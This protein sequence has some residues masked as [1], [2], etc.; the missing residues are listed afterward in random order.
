MGRRTASVGLVR[1][2]A[3]SQLDP[4]GFY[5]PS[6]Y[7]ENEVISVDDED[8]T[9]WETEPTAM[10]LAYQE[11]VY[12]WAAKLIKADRLTP[13]VDVGCGTAFK[14]MKHL[15][16]VTDTVVG[17]DQASGIERA[18]GR[19]TGATFVEGDLTDDALWEQLRAL[20]P[21]F[22]L[23]ADVVEHVADPRALV[24]NLASLVRGS[25]ARLLISTPDRSLMEKSPP[26]GPPTNAL[27][28]R[29]WIPDEFRRLLESAGL[30]VVTER[31]LLPR[32]YLRTTDEFMRMQRRFRQRR[33]VPDPKSCMAFLVVAAD[34]T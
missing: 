31:H 20:R 24:E 2:N 7:I 17:A 18:R 32:S 4:D 11:P 28:V 5:L 9:F 22:V 16:P 30:R 34:P 1:G 23:C 26:L 15:A 21:G 12:R 8:S 10:D 13:V 25:H 19:Y 6:E 3:E 33:P 29:E 14:M 27:H